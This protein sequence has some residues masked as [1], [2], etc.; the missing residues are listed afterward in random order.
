MS[1]ATR[2]KQDNGK[3]KE[4]SAKVEDKKNGSK[5]QAAKPRAEKSLS[6]KQPEGG[7][8]ANQLNVAQLARKKIADLLV[9]AEEMKLESLAGLRKQEI[10]VKLLEGQAK[11]NGTIFDEGVLEVMPDGFG[12]LRSQSYNY[13]PG[14]DDIYV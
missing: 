4:K 1:Q 2:A 13:L 7:G 14:P 12:F 9:I 5:P 6:E 8:S 11:R 10:I 3:E